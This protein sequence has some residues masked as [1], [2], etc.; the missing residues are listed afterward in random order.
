M[1]SGESVICGRSVPG[2]N[3]FVLVLACCFVAASPLTARAQTAPAVAPPI[4]KDDPL[5]AELRAKADTIRP[6]HEK[7]QAL[8][9][10]LKPEEQGSLR[11]S[12]LFTPTRRLYATLLPLL[13]QGRRAEAEDLVKKAYAVDARQSGL[14]TSLIG[15]ANEIDSPPPASPPPSAQGVAGV[16]KTANSSSGNRERAQ[17]R[18][19]NLRD[20]D[21]REQ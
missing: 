7:A 9:D 5:L 16:S 6:Y 19:T 2:L 11:T 21:D 17:H 3:R 18:G 10:G 14:I 1:R 12:L 8:W 20:A 15:Y 13:R 4:S